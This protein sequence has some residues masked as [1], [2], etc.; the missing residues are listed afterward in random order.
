MVIVVADVLAKAPVKL[1]FV[2]KFVMKS[3]VVAVKKNP[4]ATLADI[5][6]AAALVVISIIVRNVVKF[7]VLLVV[8]TSVVAI[9]AMIVVAANAEVLPVKCALQHTREIPVYVFPM[10]K[11][12]EIFVS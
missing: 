8:L 2:V 10:A 5:T 4:A 12:A 11:S 3:N 1:S 6:S 7:A 9:A